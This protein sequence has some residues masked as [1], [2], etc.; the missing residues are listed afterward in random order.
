MDLISWY[1]KF[2]CTIAPKNLKCLFCVGCGVFVC[3]H[4]LSSGRAITTDVLSCF[5]VAPYIMAPQGPQGITYAKYATQ[6][7]ANLSKWGLETRVLLLVL[8]RAQ[9]FEN[10][11]F[12]SFG[13]RIEWISRVGWCWHAH[14][15]TT[16]KYR[17]IR[18]PHFFTG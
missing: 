16:D 9:D 3:S 4:V 2:L 13:S 7:L 12:H 17:L 10:L 15:H 18:E 14:F 5:T 1:L 11:V 6:L 8:C